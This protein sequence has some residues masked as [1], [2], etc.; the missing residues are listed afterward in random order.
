MWKISGLVMRPD[1]VILDTPALFLNPGE[2]ALAEALATGRAPESAPETQAKVAAA[3]LAAKQAQVAEARGVYEN[4]WSRGELS[5]AYDAIDSGLHADVERRY[6]RDVRVEAW[7]GFMED[8]MDGDP[9][10][11]IGMPTF[12]QPET[13]AKTE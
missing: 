6:G 2:E 13:P 1:H 3:E 11:T 12:D 7:G 5:N 10:Q 8:H 4:A 9:M